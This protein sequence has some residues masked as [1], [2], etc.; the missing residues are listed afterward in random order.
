[1][2]SANEDGIAINMDAVADKIDNLGMTREEVLHRIAG[3][4]PIDRRLLSGARDDA[5]IPIDDGLLGAFSWT[6]REDVVCNRLAKISVDAPKEQVRLWRA[7]LNSYN[8]LAS[9][10]YRNL[11]RPADPAFKHE[12][13]AAVAAFESSIE[14]HLVGSSDS[15]VRLGFRR[16][17]PQR[18]SG[19]N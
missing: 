18:R 2:P 1:L 5:L 16:L 3:R 9:S 15:L 10:K 12:L 8:Y 13:E 7:L 6:N 4:M 17:L 19:G 11:Q 14:N